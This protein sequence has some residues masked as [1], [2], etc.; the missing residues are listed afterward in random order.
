M[1]GIDD[2][3][4]ARK[5]TTY[6]GRV[7][8]NK[9]RKIKQHARDYD[10]MEGLGDESDITSSGHEWDGG[11]EDEADD[12]A[13]DGEEDK[14]MDDDNSN[15]EL[16]INEDPRP[17]RTLVISLRYPQRP[18]SMPTAQEQ[19]R[20]NLDSNGLSD[21]APPPE[22]NPFATPL[23]TNTTIPSIGNG[24]SPSKYDTAMDNEQ[25]RTPQNP[26]TLPSDTPQSI[27]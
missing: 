13:D 11:D 2:N 17:Q 22:A 5:S 6:S 12:H 4:E 15:D 21:Q 25:H 9:G 7:T 16:A 1:D 14:E 27:V 10:S 24:F 19:T 26:T 23:N 8:R 18:S 3:E 20:T